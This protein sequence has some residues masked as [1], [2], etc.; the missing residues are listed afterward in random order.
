MFFD[1]ISFIY[2]EETKKF[3]AVEAKGWHRYLYLVP[4]LGTIALALEAAK[5]ISDQLNSTGGLTKDDTENIR[6]I[7]EEGRTQKVDEMEIEMSREVAN[8]L[9]LKGIK[10]VNAT[11]GSQGETKYVLKV[12]YKYDD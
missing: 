12:K 1:P 5:Y 3:E 11:L 4:S 7:I 6:K 8:G 2:N 9:N 10:G